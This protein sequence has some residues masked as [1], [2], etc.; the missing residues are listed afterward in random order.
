M[1]LR[2]IW[3][4]TGNSGLESFR[5][6]TWNCTD[7]SLAKSTDCSFR[8]PEFNSKQIHGVSQPSVME[9]DAF[10]WCTSRQIQCTH[11]SNIR[12]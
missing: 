5:T 6:T 1:L 8:D 9:S 10:Y 2:E 4:K 12:K 3:L 7:G 11:M